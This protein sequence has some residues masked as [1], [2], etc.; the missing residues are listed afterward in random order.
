MG[1]LGQK[2]GR[3][4]FWPFCV[5]KLN[6]LEYGR[7]INI[8]RPIASR[9]SKRSCQTNMRNHHHLGPVLT[10]GRS[11]RQQGGTPFSPHLSN[12]WGQNHGRLRGS[13]ALPKAVRP[14][15]E[16]LSHSPAGGYAVILLN[17]FANR[18]SFYKSA[19]PGP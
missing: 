8:C 15:R 16:T 2:T 18:D 12:C 5:L 6:T 11:R 14:P 19:S 10:A 17:F 1:L 7:G 3:I 4:V 13:R 9:V